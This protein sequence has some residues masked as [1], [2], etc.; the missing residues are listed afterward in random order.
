MNK[1][2]WKAIH[3][4]G[5]VDKRK[6]FNSIIKRKIHK[7]SNNDVSKLKFSNLLLKSQYFRV[8]SDQT[9]DGK[10]ERRHSRNQWTEMDWNGWI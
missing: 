8:G 7:Q 9:G 10:S 1:E 6:K 4:I 3:K 2:Y 5:N